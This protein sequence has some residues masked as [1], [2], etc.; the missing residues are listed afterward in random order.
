MPDSRVQV[1]VFGSYTSGV[2]AQCVASEELPLIATYRPSA[3]SVTVGYQR[4]RCMS[5]TRDHEFVAGSKIVVSTMPSWPVDRP[6][7]PPTTSS[8]PSGRAAPP[9][10]KTLSGALIVVNVLGD[11]GFHTTDGCGCCQPSQATTL[12]LYSRELLIATIGN[13]DR[14]DHWPPAWV[15][16]VTAA[17]GAEAGPVPTAFVALTVNVYAVPF[18]SPA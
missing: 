11:E 3:S 8:R 6:P 14:P 15:P 18:V 4:G 13:V 7:Y 16:G 5:A 2:S 9:S 1:F 10:Q 12:P 17:E